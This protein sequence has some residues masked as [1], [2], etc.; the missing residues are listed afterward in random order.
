MNWLGMTHFISAML[1]LTLGAIVLLLRPKGGR[2]HRQLG[3]AYVVAML[4]LNATALMI[5]R[6][7]GGFGPFHVAALISLATV[8]M[9]VPAGIRARRMRQQGQPAR[10]ATAVE[11]HYYWMTYSYVGLVAA[12]VAETATRAPIF[13]DAGGPGAT[14][15][16]V[17]IAASL[18][19]FVIGA[20]WIRA[21]SA[22]LLAPFRR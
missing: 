16:M 21:R 6:L 7:F 8:L 22:P 11:H 17:V 9:G 4:A 3:W 5:Y 1:A 20:R 14:F 13:R 18:L 2:R 10:R 19:V 12:A 15:G